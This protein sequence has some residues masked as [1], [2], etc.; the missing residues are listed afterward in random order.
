MPRLTDSNLQ[1]CTVEFRSGRFCGARS[2]PEMPFPI[3][4]RHAL[5]LFEE[6][7]S[8]TTPGNL[9]ALVASLGPSGVEALPQPEIRM[10]YPVV[11]YLLV[12]ELVKIGF[13]TNLSSRLRS[14]P[15]S[16][17]VMATEP[18]ERSLER[19]RHREFNEYL[20]HGREWFAAGRRL[21]DHIEQLQSSR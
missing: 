16:A 3:C 18:G 17:Q 2:A 9:R 10:V 11:Y 6:M 21:M 15:P 1:S 12:D 7:A 14:Y 20:T 13:T 5:D 19:Q 8:R 4:M